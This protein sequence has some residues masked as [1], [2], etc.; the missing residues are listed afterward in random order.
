MFKAGSPQE[1]LAKQKVDADIAKGRS[2]GYFPDLPPGC[3]FAVPMGLVP[4]GSSPDPDFTDADSHRLIRNWSD[5]RLTARG[6]V[7]ANVDKIKSSM[8]TPVHV[9]RS[10]HKAILAAKKKGTRPCA[11]KTDWKGAYGN[12]AIAHGHLWQMASCF[13]KHGCFLRL[14]GDFG[15]ATCGYRHELRAKYILTLLHVA[16]ARLFVAGDNTCWLSPLPTGSPFHDCLP[17]QPKDGFG[18]LAG[19][20][21][22]TSVGAQ[23][24][25]YLRL[26]RHKV[27]PPPGKTTWH[28]P[29][30]DFVRWVDDWCAFLASA[31]EAHVTMAA[32]AFLHRCY[33]VPLNPEKTFVDPATD[34]S[35]IVFDG[36]NGQ[37]GIP[38]TKRKKYLGLIN[39]LLDP[40]R[41][42]F[43]GLRKFVGAAV[44]CCLALPLGKL[45]LKACFT[46]MHSANAHTTLTLCP[47]ARHELLFW[48]VLLTDAPMTRILLAAPSDVSSADVVVHIDWAPANGRQ[49]IGIAVLSHGLYT[50][51]FVPQWFLDICPSDARAPSSPTFEAFALAS[52]FVCFPDLAANHISYVYTDNDPFLKRSSA[53]TSS[54]SPSLDAALKLG[55]LHAAQLNARYVLA[56]VPSA[57]NI[58][59]WLTHVSDQMPQ[60]ERAL[61]SADI[62]VPFLRRSPASHM[63]PSAWKALQHS[64]RVR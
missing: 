49:K 33:G 42:S 23:R 14:V 29:S 3:P 27:T 59:N 18:S 35:G 10:F 30:L 41:F 44:W 19:N 7:T 39:S 58:A 57:L 21:I 11:A 9:L 55:A 6:S 4:K 46:L 54:G 8:M 47:A 61:R 62:S 2:T 48:K 17:V 64:S 53:L 1:K 45:F 25:A 50:S 63:P 5:P 20:T 60:F 26:T 24:L 31:P 51:T 52:Y 43:E 36:H 37:V 40:A 15:H 32:M 28:K 34:F 16:E 56:R 38:N 12:N 13:E 22:F